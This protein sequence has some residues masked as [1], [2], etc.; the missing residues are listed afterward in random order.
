MHAPHSG[1]KLD[2]HMHTEHIQHV[3]NCLVAKA[4]KGTTAGF[5]RLQEASLLL[6]R[7]SAP[8]HVVNASEYSATCWGGCTSLQILSG[9]SS[10]TK[11]SSDPFGCLTEEA[12]QQKFAL[13]SKAQLHAGGRAAKITVKPLHLN[14]AFLHPIC[15]QL[16]C[17]NNWQS[18]LCPCGADNHPLHHHHMFPA[19]CLCHVLLESRDSS[20]SHSAR[21]TIAKPL[22]HGIAHADTRRQFLRKQSGIHHEQHVRHPFVLLE[23][24]RSYGKIKRFIAV[25]T[26]EV[27]GESL[28][29]FVG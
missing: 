2:L 6:Q 5:V 25:S 18:A 23:S 11:T 19:L 3:L 9:S 10:L 27:Y 24:A 21:A 15:P 26:D 29:T 16:V 13:T 14:T 28:D 17:K 7:H 4:A 8:Q 20:Q 22:T 1:Y 12:A